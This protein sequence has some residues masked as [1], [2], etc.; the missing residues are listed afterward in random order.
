MAIPY[1]PGTANPN[2]R[3]SDLDANQV[4]QHAFD[5]TECRLR[6]DATFNAGG[7]GIDVNI[8]H[9]NDSIRLGD[10]TNFLTSTTI[11]PDVALDV[12]LIN[13]ITLDKDGIGQT[14]AI[15]NVAMAVSGSEYSFALPLGTKKITI[16]S[17]AKGRLQ[18]AWVAATTGTTYLTVQPGTS[19]TIDNIDVNAA[20]TLYMQSTK[21]TDTLEVLYWI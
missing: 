3:P 11:G 13:D 20:L 5:E 4:L 6:V 18:I 10:G 16:R 9:T 17:R 8:D 1:G 12:N 19:Y 15:A 7:G 21:N 2:Y 14:P